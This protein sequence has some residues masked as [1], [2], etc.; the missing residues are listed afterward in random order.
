MV[1]WYVILVGDIYASTFH[2]VDLKN[3][4]LQDFR[5]LNIDFKALTL[6]LTTKLAV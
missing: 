6:S 4:L 3:S 1:G 5:D 2:R